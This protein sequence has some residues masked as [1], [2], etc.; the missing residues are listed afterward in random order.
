MADT[1]VREVVAALRIASTAAALDAAS[2]PVD[3]TPL[4]LAPDE[5][6]LV[7]AVHADAPEAHAIVFADTGWVRFR[8]TPT[9]GAEVMRAGAAWPP[10]VDG[11]G[12][13]MIL[14]VPAKLVIADDEWWVLVLGAVA[15]E[16]EERFDEVRA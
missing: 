1:V 6:L 7:D 10:P 5:V 14:G 11:L 15:D 9:G 16:F 8:L 13:G 3:A 4:R 2:W 12:Q